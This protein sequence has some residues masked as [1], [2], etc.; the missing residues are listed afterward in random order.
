V[1][2]LWFVVL[3]AGLLF[4]GGC[5]GEDA[6]IAIQPAPA[7]LAQ[8]TGPWQPQ[9]FALDPMLRGRIEQA[10]RADMERKPGSVAALV[11]VRGA[12]VAVV[13]MVGPSAG[14]CDSLQISEIGN[15]IGAG[16]G[17]A[18]RDAEPLPAIDPTRLADAQY[19]SIGGGDLKVQG[20]SVVGRAGDA[21]A[22]VV[23]EPEGVPPILATLE[24][25]WFAGWWPAIVPPN[26][27]AD[28][29]LA[30]EVVVRAYDPAGALLDETSP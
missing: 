2:R 14:M 11:D 9:P 3:A 5:G 12:S 7:S 10:C 25:G 26:Q 23:I 4:P 28:P 18:G 6:A 15:V 27:V 29:A 21:I 24:N 22:A 17:W 13:R 19:G 8:L 1:A 30:Q 20:F 16:G